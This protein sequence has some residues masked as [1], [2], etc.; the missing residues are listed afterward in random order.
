MNKLFNHTVTV[1]RSALLGVVMAF[2]II[3]PNVGNIPG[4]G[5]QTAKAD[6]L[7]CIIFEADGITCG[8]AK[9]ILCLASAAVIQG[10]I[11]ASGYGGA[12]QL[13]IQASLR[14]GGRVGLQTAADLLKRMGSISIPIGKKTYTVD[15][16]K[17]ADNLAAWESGIFTFLLK[18][19]LEMAYDICK[20]LICR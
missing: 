13:T 6:I 20:C 17:I 8:W 14:A 9:R 11:I 19:A 18:S 5:T 12:T 7:E 2:L 4:V 10:L 16:A 15:F 1:S 3:G